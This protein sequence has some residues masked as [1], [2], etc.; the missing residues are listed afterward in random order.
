MVL[1]GSSLLAIWLDPS[2]PARF[3]R[4][5]Y[6]LL[7]VYLAWSMVAAAV[8]WMTS[9]PEW[10]L[11]LGLAIDVAM[12]SLLVFVTSGPSSPFF[13]FFVFA[14]VSATLNW[15]WRATAVTGVFLLAV[16]LALGA[17]SVV[18]LHGEGFDLIRFVTRSSYLIVM[19]MLL[20]YLGAHQGWLRSKLFQLLDQPADLATESV[21]V[22]GQALAQ[23]VQ[24]F[25]AERALF[26]WEEHE[27]PWVRWGFWDGAQA[28]FERGPPGTFAPPV[29]GEIAD[30]GFACRAPDAARAFLRVRTIAGE[31]SWQGPVLHPEL[32]QRFAVRAALSVPVAGGGLH[33][34][35]FLL[36]PRHGEGD[37]LLLAEVFARR[38]AAQLE[39][40][41]LL[42]QLQGEARNEMRAHL[43]RELH[44][45]VIQSLT[46]A[47]LRLEAVQR[48]LPVDARARELIRSVAVILGD[49]QEDLRA[50]VRQS[51]PSAIQISRVSVPLAERLQDLVQRVS[52]RW[53]LYVELVCS[54][55]AAV[56][57][58]ALVHEVDRIAH[59]ALVNA[60]RHGVAT[61]ATL[62]VTL[63]DG[64]LRLAIA[65]NG[66]GFPF[67]GHYAMADLSTQKLGPVMLK[68]RVLALGGELT[69]DSSAEGAR[70]E[71][72]LPWAER[73]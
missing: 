25:G 55:D 3:A 11:V 37:D 70:L 16:Y 38:M 48:L 73:A 71:I 27:E 61:R 10:W 47:G 57:Q 21:T 43:G 32:R 50:F 4:L 51:R 69:I 30:R 59:E 72:R 42:R 62:E 49:E 12:F 46:A 64:C 44:D 19:G 17:Y 40:V 14:L 67:V 1:A 35:L 56:L 33:G 8:A 22:I 7:I 15:G 26:V 5:V 58:G 34:R 45:G 23:A 29:A 65:D 54:S 2:E 28:R 39:N 68:Q 6:L 9:P 41:F 60:V 63:A 20:G 52:D 36:E 31:Q 18:A 53:G 66:R 13:V 24:L